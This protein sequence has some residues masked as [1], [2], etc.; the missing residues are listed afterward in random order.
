LTIQNA[1]AAPGGT[2]PS[3]SLVHD[4]NGY[5]FTINTTAW[6]I[7]LTTTPGSG[8]KCS[9][10][11]NTNGRVYFTLAGSVLCFDTATNTI[12]ATASPNVGNVDLNGVTVDEATGNVY[13]SAYDGLNSIG[14]LYKYDA[15]LG[16]FA[17]FAIPNSGNIGSVNSPVF[18][19]ASGL[20]YIASEDSFSN[21]IIY[22]INPSTGNA[23]A[24]IPVVAGFGVNGLMGYSHNGYDFN[25]NQAYF[26]LQS[27]AGF[28]IDVYVVC[29][30]NNTLL[31]RANALGVFGSPFFSY[32]DHFRSEI[33]ARDDTVGT[34]VSLERYSP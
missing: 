24:T 3:G 32:E 13:L 22:G 31:G 5:T 7:D 19:P 17:Q 23:D 26:G 18:S 34:Q 33:V 10:A 27:L 16:S 20:V 1:T 2:V 4:S 29:T 6:P 12:I 25:T 15:S 14:Y 9:W 28:N 8:R 21:V 11:N 30:T